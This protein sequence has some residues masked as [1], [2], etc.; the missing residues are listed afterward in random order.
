MLSMSKPRIV[1][2]G[3]KPQG[4]AWLRSL[5]ESD[6]FDIVAGV[7][8][9]ID[10]QWWGWDPFEDILRE[11][12]IPIVQRA[13]LPSLEYDILWSIMYG[14]IIEGEHI[15]HAK[16]FGLNLH[17]SPLPRY[18]GCNGYTHAILEDAA[19]Y[20]TTFHF[21]APELDGGDIIAQEIFP[22]DPNETSK[23][24][25]LR[26]MGIS[27]TLFKRMLPHV[28]AKELTSTKNESGDEPIRKRS[29]LLDLK[30]LQIED[31]NLPSIYR[32]AR[33][34][35]FLPFEPTFFHLGDKKFYAYLPGSEARGAGTREESLP[36]V[37][38]LGGLMDHCRNGSGALI[39]CFDRPLA[40]LEAGDYSAMYN[41]F[42]PH[43]P[44][45]SPKPA[46]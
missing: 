16:W 2:L 37:S 35:D 4:A 34:F 43:Y 32:A 30:E 22:I 44:W 11:H 10:R 39:D 7:P 14:F 26:T 33:A 41:I 15:H 8:R 28:A 45:L 46:S 24:L 31:A 3:E 42:V 29:S 18:R 25:Y 12:N 38:A 19:T 1:V 17:E 40:V 9:F 21:L 36:H 23:E 5:L 27:H 13:D 6:L 20:G